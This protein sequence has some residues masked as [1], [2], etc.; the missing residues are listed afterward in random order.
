MYKAHILNK[1]L[2]LF[3]QEQGM[4]DSLEQGIILKLFLV[5]N[6]D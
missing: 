5:N 6:T 1:N 2:L 3:C 4:L